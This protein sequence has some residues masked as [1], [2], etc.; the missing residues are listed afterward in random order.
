MP[1]RPPLRFLHTSDV[2]LGAYERGVSERD[3]E[4]DTTVREM[5]GRVI[6][7]GL[8]E[9]VD[10]M[11]I[12]GDFF[13][14]ARVRDDTLHF[15]AEQ[16]ARLGAPVVV[17]PGNHDHVGP[18]SLYDR[19]DLTSLASNLTLM[20]APA[21]ETVRPGGLEVELWGR[22]HTEQDRDFAPMTGVPARDG[23]PWRIAL[24][25]GHYV[26]SLSPPLGSYPIHR[27]EISEQD[28]DY[29]AL[30]HWEQQTRVD[31]GSVLAAYSG[32]PEGLAGIERRRTLIV[33]LEQD[34]AV[35]IQSHSLDGGPTLAQGDLPLVEAPSPDGGP[36]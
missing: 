13:D 11:V 28:F 20:R 5:F 19:I 9:R 26:R 4:R 27:E 15:A 16:V 22:S 17:V 7:L 36:R 8:R 21:G 24:A 18:G 2:H 14:H 29:V 25:H 12:V 30:G 10:F 31:G 34:G 33:D 32:A 23:A 6:D 3:D 1:V 35:R